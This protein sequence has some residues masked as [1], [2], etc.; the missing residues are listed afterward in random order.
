MTNYSEGILA[1]ANHT[2][3]YEYLTTQGI[4]W[5]RFSHKEMANAE[6]D[7]MKANIRTGVVTWYSKDLSSFDNAIS[8]TQAIFPERSRDEVIN[9]LVDFNRDK[10]LSK[11]DSKPREQDVK[12]EKF[13]PNHMAEFKSGTVLSATKELNEKGFEYLT[14]KRFLSDDTVN[15]FKKTGTLVSDNLGNTVFL[16][17]R[18]HKT[19]GADIISPKKSKLE[20]RIK[21]RP[22]G[23]FNLLRPHMKLVG[24][25]SASDGGYSFTAFS[26]S[27]SLYDKQPIR[28]YVTEA[29]IE[30]MSLF[31]LNQRAGNVENAYYL[32]MSGLKQQAIYSELSHIQGMY[33]DNPIDVVMATNADKPGQ[34]FIRRAVKEFPKTEG[35]NWKLLQPRFKGSDWNEMLEYQK[36]GKLESRIE[37]Q[38][39]FSRAA[40]LVQT[41]TNTDTKMKAPE[42]SQTVQTEKQLSVKEPSL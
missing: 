8:F 21:I 17:Q 16:W 32:S 24:L 23:G 15:L 36:T 9:S 14:Q 25:N 6:H 3:E 2:N 38:K 22:D 7:S 26:D 34:D 41:M 5:Q 33:T 1:L 31:E 29:P 10:D 27:K 13:D 28:M 18:D 37:K 4:E 35:V 39:D 20:S 12:V 19:I 11:G 40:K 42:Q 30:A